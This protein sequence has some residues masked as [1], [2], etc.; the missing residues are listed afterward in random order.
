MSKPKILIL[1]NELIVAEDLKDTLEDF[2]YKV[3]DIC[4][5][6]EKA[7]E[8][9]P[10]DGLEVILMDIMLKG[11]VDGITAAS[12]IQNSY[13]IPVVY[14]TAHTDDNTF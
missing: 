14:L 6:G 11:K 9:L 1:E 13:D 5:S 7:L 3:V 12:I 2:G 4:P 10:Y 8:I